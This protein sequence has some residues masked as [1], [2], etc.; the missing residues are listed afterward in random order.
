[1][2]YINRIPSSKFH[3]CGK[4]A[5]SKFSLHGQYYIILYSQSPLKTEEKRPYTE[6]GIISFIYGAN[7]L[8][9]NISE[10]MKQKK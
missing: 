9:Q 6:G 2:L 7:L 1:M 4:N 10:K 5:R 3:L 8:P